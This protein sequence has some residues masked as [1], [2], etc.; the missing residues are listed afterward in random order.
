MRIAPQAP[1][2]KCLVPSLQNCLGRI[3]RCGLVGGGVSVGFQKSTP[4]HVSLCLMVVVS[5]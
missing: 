4:F 2:F 5:T 1:I 3:R